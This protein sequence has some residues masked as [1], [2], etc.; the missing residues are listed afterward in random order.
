[1]SKK[2]YVFSN[3]NSLRPKIKNSENVTDSD[4]IYIYNL[5]EDRPL[6][7]SPLVNVDKNSFYTYGVEN[8]KIFFK[9]ISEI[10]SGD[11]TPT[12][13]SSVTPT[14]TPTSSVT[15][16]PSNTPTPTPTSSVTP[17][18][19][20]T[21][22]PTPTSS[23]TPTPTPTPSTS[24]IAPFSLLHTLDNPDPYSG[25]GSDA[26]G[27]S[28]AITDNYTIVAAVNEDDSGGN[29][30]G[31]AYIF[32]TSTGN[33]LHTL[34]NPNEFDTSDGD[35]FG[36]AVDISD[37]YAI[38]G[39][40]A[41]DDSGGNESGKAYIFDPSTGNLLHTLDNP[42]EFGTSDNDRFGDA[43]AISNNYAIVG[44]R[45][46]DDS[47]DNNSGKAYIFDPSTGNLLHTLDNPNAFGTSDGDSFGESVAISDN[48]AIVGAQYEDDSGGTSS[49][50]AYIFDPS[51]G[52]LLHTLDN[53]NEFGTSD[54]DRFGDAVAIS[55]NYAIVGALLED[56]SGGTSSGKAYIFDP[57]TGNLLHTLDNPNAF[58]TSDGDRFG[59]RLA[60]SNNY[61]VSSSI[62][63]LTA[64][65]FKF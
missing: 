20:N 57:S 51:T 2:L 6:E 43:V 29:E 45:L 11:V 3:E 38:V 32:D 59:R 37:N 50:K 56:D 62:Q 1:M 58:G 16:T 53:P 8:N 65:I 63:D 25:S 22:T 48:Y 36:S 42:N 47:G 46:E 15:Q 17:T 64:Y 26:F 4:R 28:V 44:A 34:D 14:P 10:L 9:L 60:A 7:I 61:F 41:E 49:G 40:E 39:A 52:N 13:T 12:P 35:K 19:S 5:V 30:S 24:P 18:P 27:N 23:V 55:N 21:P 33:L 54:N 31:K